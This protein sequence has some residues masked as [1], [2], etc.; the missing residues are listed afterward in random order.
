MSPKLAAAEVR[1]KD[2]SLL[3]LREAEEADAEEILAYLNRVGG[4]SDNLLFGEGGFSMPIERERAFLQSLRREERSVMLLGFDGEELVS[5]S[6]LSCFSGRERTAHRAE[7]AVSVRKDHWGRG[8]GRAAM[9]A[10]V[11]FAVSRGIEIIQLDVRADNERAI[12]LYRSLGF[13]TVGRYR[14]FFKIG[15]EYFD[16]YSMNLYLD[17]RNDGP[18]TAV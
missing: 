12:S 16:A 9:E 4:E 5:V 7:I 2:G 8:A 10:L 3:T 6:S 18:K 13:E 17:E 15:G 1:L 14:G 11:R